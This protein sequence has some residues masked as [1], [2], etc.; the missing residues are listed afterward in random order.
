MHLTQV[1]QFFLGYWGTTMTWNPA[2]NKLMY[3]AERKVKKSE[4]YWT[5]YARRKLDDPDTS[6]KDNAERVCECSRIYENLSYHS[7]LLYMYRDTNM[8]SIKIG[9]NNWKAIT[10]VWLSF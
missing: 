10:T 8:I 7:S 1:I 6:D 4:P 5:S 2:E 3:L 9:A